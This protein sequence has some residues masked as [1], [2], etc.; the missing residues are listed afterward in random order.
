MKK[1]LLF[2]TIGLSPFASF[3]Q[4]TAPAATAASWVFDPE[5]IQVPASMQSRSDVQILINEYKTIA[6]RS[7]EICGQKKLFGLKVV[8]VDGVPRV[9]YY[10]DMKSAG[11]IPSRMRP[12][13]KWK[14]LKTEWNQKDEAEFGKWVGSIGRA[15]ATGNCNSTDTCLLSSANYLKTATDEQAFHYSDCADFP[16]YLRAYFAFRKGLPFT[17]ANAVTPRPLTAID[18]QRA[19]KLQDKISAFQNVIENGGQ[20]NP[21][22]TEELKNLRKT[23]SIL[24]DLRYSINGNMAVGRK[25]VLGAEDI[26]FFNFAQQMRDV[27]STSNYRIAQN[28]GEQ[29]TLRSGDVIEETEPDFYSAAI[30]P[31][32]IRPGTVIYKVDGHAGIVYAVDPASSKPLYMDAHPDNSISKGEMDLT[33]AKGMSGRPVYGGGFKN[34]R[35]FYARQVERTYKSG[36]FGWGTETKLEWFIRMKSDQ[37]VGSSFSIEQYQLF[38]NSRLDTVPTFANNKGVQVNFLDLTRLRLS[39]G[40]YTYDPITE[41]QADLRSIC[42]NLQSRRTDVEIAVS[43]GIHQIAHP[44]TLPDNIFGADG[45]W[46]TYSTPGRDIVSKQRVL[47]MVDNLIVTK[48][49]IANH[50]PLIRANVTLN[51]FKSDALAFY[52]QFAQSCVVGYNKSNGQEQNFNL[53]EAL[54]RL[55]LMSY[56]PYDCP[57]R[58]FGAS[59]PEEL[60]TCQESADK[61]QWYQGQQF[62]RNRIEKTPNEPMGWSLQTLARPQG[63]IVDANLARKLNIRKMIEEL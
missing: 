6:Q 54:K 31:E 32:G 12:K 11:C 48:N 55:P 10:V 18:Q 29:K 56:D 15:R 4:Q 21:A 49:K 3:A 57:E 47:N 2:L 23:Q 52:D 17:Y 25:W 53:T 35:P 20:L 62:L 36:L 39:G 38:P 30:S 37:E 43:K 22:Q 1:A 13:E 61:T 58:R 16:F 59:T 14:V 7:P 5:A 28:L 26:S 46:E 50:D 33:W 51:S 19:E 27:V 41:F 9:R 34:F 63:N 44:L 42:D 45:D 40:T 60:A 24:Q 8:K